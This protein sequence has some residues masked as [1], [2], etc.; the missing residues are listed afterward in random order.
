M[1]FTEQTS[2][3]VSFCEIKYFIFEPPHL[4]KALYEARK[5]DYLLR[6]ALKHR[7]E[8][9]LYPVFQENHRLVVK[10]RQLTINN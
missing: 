7:Y 10:F 2:K 3:K 4:R 5:S 1:D 9:L 8:Q 6:R